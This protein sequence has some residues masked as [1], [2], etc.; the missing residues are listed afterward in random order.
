MAYV[1]TNITFTPPQVYDKSQ[2]GI[3][4][5]LA[6]L[7]DDSQWDDILMQ[8][9]FQVGPNTWGKQAFADLGGRYLAAH[10][11]TLRAQA[12]VGL[13]GL[14]QPT[15]PL[16]NVAVG[17][18]SKG[19]AQP[20]GIAGSGISQLALMATSYGIEFLRLRRLYCARMATT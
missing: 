9:D 6:G 4:P 3:A 5:E 10:L 16:S 7:L 2:G 19:F 8:V 17:G 15:G 12:N 1:P 20:G 11:G 13:S 14:A 18:V